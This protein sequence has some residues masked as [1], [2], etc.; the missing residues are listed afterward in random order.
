[1]CWHRQSGSA[2]ML[3]C[4]APTNGAVYGLRY[5]IAMQRAAAAVP[6]SQPA[7]EPRLAALVTP[8][9]RTSLSFAALGS[10]RALGDVPLLMSEQRLWGSGG[11]VTATETAERR[12]RGSSACMDALAFSASQEELAECSSTRHARCDSFGA[13]SKFGFELGA[14]VFDM[15]WDSDAD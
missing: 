13:D 11:S 4:T 6:P 14:A 8:P 7:P 12:T 9:P 15:D 3:P 5:N 10:P 2:A 1:M